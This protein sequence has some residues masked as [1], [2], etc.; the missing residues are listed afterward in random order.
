MIKIV[1]DS[2]SDLQPER[3][4]EL[5][6]EVLPLLVHFGKEVYR[7]GI[8]LTTEAFYEKL[9]KAETLPTTSQ[10]N[11][12]VFTAAFQKH[13][14]QGDEVLGIFLSSEMSGTCQSAMIAKDMLESDR[15]QVVDSRTV[16]FA[17][18]LL[19]EQA[20]I[21]RDQGLSLKELTQEITE[22]TQRTRL[23]AV[24]DTLKYLKMGGR[25]SAATAMVG[26]LLG[27]SPIVCIRDGKVESAGKVRGRKAG[28]AWIR[29]EM[30]RCPADLSLPIGFGHTNVPQALEENMA[31]FSDL[32]ETAPLISMSSIGSVVGTHTGPGATGLTYFAAK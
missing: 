17:L 21:L 32:V 14:D 26:G 9:S 28:F 23:L 15:V 25:I 2:T 3:A 20:C 19:V 24:V 8:D 27:I 1:T 31:Y 4:R 29:E 12:E 18:G 22:L 5:G 6:V 11:P 10:I 7:D 13:L 30:G 16:T